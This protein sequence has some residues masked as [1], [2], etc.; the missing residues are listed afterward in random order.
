M[1]D[2]KITRTEKALLIAMV[3]VISSALAGLIIFC[4]N[5]PGG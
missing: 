4:E 1:N 2:Y 3:I 5:L